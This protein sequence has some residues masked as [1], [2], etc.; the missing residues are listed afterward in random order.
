MRLGIALAAM[1]LCLV[2]GGIAGFL[3]AGS[4]QRPVAVLSAVPIDADLSSEATKAEE[5]KPDRQAD[6]L[7][8]NQD[9]GD[10]PEAAEMPPIQGDCE[11]HGQVL[12]QDGKPLSGVT[13]WLSAGRTHGGSRPPLW[14]LQSDEEFQR[15]L[16]AMLDQT[17]QAELW[18]RAIRRP[19]VTDEEGRFRI[20][21]LPNMDASVLATAEHW[22]FDSQRVQLTA[23]HEVNFIGE[24]RRRV[25]LRVYGPDGTPAQRVS[26]I[27]TGMLT[28]A[29][30]ESKRAPRT[31]A[32]WEAD[33]SAWFFLAPGR[34]LVSNE[35]RD[36]MRVDKEVEVPESG[37]VET[38]VLHLLPALGIRGWISAPG[39]WSP[40]GFRV[41]ISMLDRE[42]NR[43][44][45]NPSFD[46]SA[47]PTWDEER[48]QLT[49][50]HT[51][52]EPG[53][54]LV[55]GLIR[56]RVV[57]ETQ[58]RVEDGEA[59]C[60]L[61]MVVP[62]NPHLI[63][64]CFSPTGEPETA[65]GWTF[66]VPTRR[67]RTI[68]A[69][70][71]WVQDQRRTLIWFASPETEVPQTLLN[72]NSELVITAHSP[73]Y[74]T[75]QTTTAWFPGVH[76]TLRFEP[77]A[78]LYFT[79]ENIPRHY[80]RYVSATMLTGPRNEEVRRRNLSQQPDESTRT[81]SWPPRPA[82]VVTIQFWSSAWGG[83]TLMEHKVTLVPGENTLTV[84][85][86]ELYDVVV[87][88]SA[89]QAQRRFVLRGANIKG[90]SY[91]GGGGVL[92]IYPDRS[93]RLEGLPAGT[94]TLQPDTGV[95]PSVTF[96]LPAERRIAVGG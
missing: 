89:L 7:A 63:V 56:N 91:Y 34:W 15:N 13:V 2:T 47:A 83:T 96:T 50:R 58:V 45:R 39:A 30:L 52:L 9:S 24:F 75:A 71:V 86:P 6:L 65:L 41:A 79:V 92:M 36:G 32:N 21:N 27:A 68:Q 42:G 74:G 35:R 84:P 4:A 77:Q 1:G 53:T 11:I 19:T 31:H 49:F 43:V 22:H 73:T 46:G 59:E 64:E 12:D 69:S 54:Y 17:R 25:P 20:A 85:F 23:S 95:G 48:K 33:G 3:I 87:D 57:A 94:Y 80:Q 16:Q 90:I 81:F 78:T 8:T 28:A 40:G 14:G 70:E 93:A 67:Q 82:G 5:A 55:S 18:R 44:E 88:G 38:V 61:H 72:P 60:E 76:V 37:P 29:Q 66:E 62:R 10:I 51:V 26:I